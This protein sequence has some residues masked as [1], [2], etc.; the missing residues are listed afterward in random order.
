V[1]GRRST[2]VSQGASCQKVDRL[3]ALHQDTLPTR[4]IK[5]GGSLL[6][7]GELMGELR[8]WL[9]T[10]PPARNL[11]V[12]GGGSLADAVRRADRLHGLG[13]TAAHWLCVRAMGVNSRMIAA[14]L[15]EAAY[16][17]SLIDTSPKDLDAA[18]RDARS[19]QAHL[20]IVDAWHFLRDLEPRCAVAPL[21]Q[22]WDATS[23]SIAAQLAVVCRAAE[24]VLLKSAL[25]AS[26]CCTA[27]A[28]ANGYVDRHFPRIAE[29]VATIRCVNLCKR[30]F[31][32]VTLRAAK[33]AFTLGEWPA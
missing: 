12:V 31:P 19:R 11:L 4:V 9:A 20:A 2:V 23:D 26:P 17:T 7:F 15:P 14:L 28:A 18:H 16:A 22:S 29:A 30:E 1:V 33:E 27:A 8:R 10:Q 13:E 25:P 5:L 6:D 32:E 21:P 24:L 3:L